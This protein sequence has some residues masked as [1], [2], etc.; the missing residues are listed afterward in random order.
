MRDTTRTVPFARAA[1]AVFDLSLESMIWTRRSLLMAILLGVPP[2]LALV[3]RMM[4]E[5]PMSGF[6]LYGMFIAFYYVRNVL[7]LVALFYGT[8]LIAD[9]VEGRTL[10]YLL[11]RPIGRKAIMTGKM[12]AYLATTLAMTLPA[13]MLTFF[14]AVPTRGFHGLGARVPALFQDLGVMALTL[15]VY[16]AL[17]ALLGVALRRPM[18][19]GL[20]FLFGWELVANLPGDLPRYT[21]TAWLRS[22]IT[23]RPVD[24]GMAEL[25]GQ[26]LPAAL[27][28]Q[29]LSVMIVVFVSGA[30]W[31]FSRREYV[32]EQ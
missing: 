27:C 2:V 15:V 24:E 20:L 21:I 9:E 5:K 7:P 30:L 13:A 6:D 16:G 18:I 3:F 23:H 19:P 1:K 26:V 12:A 8:S 14:V 32:L 28:L 17:F 22:L 11:T 10:T 4:S 25:F 29:V 31:I